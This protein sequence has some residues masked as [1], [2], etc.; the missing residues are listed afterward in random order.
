MFHHLLVPLDGSRLAEAALPAAAYLGQRLGARVALVHVIER[1]A[2]QVVH[3]ERHLAAPAEADAYLS[4]VAARAFPAG[5]AV[6]WH[7]HTTA[8]S[9]VARSL[10]EHVEELGPD[11]IVM[12]THGKGGLRDWLFGSIPQQVIA[13]GES[14]VL[15]IQPP[16]F[17]RA[18]AFA[19]RRLLVPLDGDPAH[20]SG[21]ET[22]IG[23]G[24]ACAGELRLVMV[25]PTPAT[26]A[27]EARVRARFL[28]GA[29]SALLD[30]HEDGASAYLA[31]R[32]AL[33]QAQ[34]APAAAQVGRGDPAQ[35]IIR[36]ARQADSD[37]VALGTHGRGGLA[38]FWAESVAPQV[39][40][41]A[42]IPLL[43]A[44]AR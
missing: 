22:A 21:L 17:G 37:L 27:G 33:A 15:L 41:R 42:H 25:V 20:E 16:R 32:V 13:L 19:C 29:T 4:E 39:I 9:D 40:R 12:C 2:P 1:D 14:P 26:L 28:P 24:R 30:L 18:P 43:L 6:E 10:A 5:S 35:V 11:L 7:V 23:L 36:T 34:G 8:V 38:A 44:P 3:G 31:G